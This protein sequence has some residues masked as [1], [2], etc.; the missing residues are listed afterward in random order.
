MITMT[1]MITMITM[2]TMVYPSSNKCIGELFV[3]Y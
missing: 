2:I 1:K 3:Y